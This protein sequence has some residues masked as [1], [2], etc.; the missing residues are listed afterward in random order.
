MVMLIP[1]PTHPWLKKLS[2]AYIPGPS[3]SL[4][5]R[6]AS[7]LVNTFESQWHRIQ[8][9]P[10]DE[11]EVLLTTARLGEPLGWRE[12]LMFT[13]RRRYRLQHAPTVFTIVHALPEQFRELMHKIQQI[14][15]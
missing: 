14:L 8:A 15:Q 5:E 10:S 11:T 12:S 9:I 7:D 13:A 1:I 2:F 6:V 3:E 4:A